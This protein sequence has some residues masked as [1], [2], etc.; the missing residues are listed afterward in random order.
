MP[1]D[2][3]FAALIM[4]EAGYEPDHLKKS[5]GTDF[6]AEVRSIVAVQDA[7]LKAAPVDRAIPIGREREPKDLYE[8]KYGLCYDRSRVIEKCSPGSA[9]RRGMCP[10]IL[11]KS[12]LVLGSVEAAGGLPCRDGGPHEQ[13]LDGGRFQQAVDRAR[14]Q[15]RRHIARR[16]CRAGASTLG[17]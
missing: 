12:F 14:C 2:K 5:D 17:A 7:V 9:F 13:R 4:K 6:E 11:R 15:P 8:L 3:R 10:S 16:S 1:D